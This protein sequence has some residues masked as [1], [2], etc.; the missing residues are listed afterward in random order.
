LLFLRHISKCS[1]GS[2]E[3]RLFQADSKL[4]VPCTQLQAA[5]V[6]CFT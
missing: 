5:A 4:Q 1:R 6:T 2:S 3:K